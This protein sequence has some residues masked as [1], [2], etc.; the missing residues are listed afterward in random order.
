MAAELANTGGVLGAFVFDQPD[1]RE[2]ISAMVRAAAAHGLALDFH[3]DE[4]LADG[5]DGLEMIPMR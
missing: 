1:R 4:G 2:G 5:L 3:V